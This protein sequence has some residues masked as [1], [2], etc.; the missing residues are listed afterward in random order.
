LGL[1][2]R[3]ADFV[4][5]RPAQL[6]EWNLGFQY[7]AFKDLVLEATYSGER[8][9]RFTSRVNLNQIP[10]AKGFAG[11]TTQADR[12]FPNVGNQVVMDSALGNNFYNAL[13]LRAEKE[14]ERRLEF[15]CQ[16]HLVEKSRGPTL[17]FESVS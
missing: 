17:A 5:S 8:G 11:H 1:L 6:H 4:N 2:I 13:N 3:T 14:A 15:S 9:S 16:L 7:Q 12:L 10:W